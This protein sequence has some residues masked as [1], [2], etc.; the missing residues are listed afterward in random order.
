MELIN[1]AVFYKTIKEKG[2][3]KKKKN[4]LSEI[5]DDNTELRA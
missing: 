1:N 3:V 2:V 4:V 5:I